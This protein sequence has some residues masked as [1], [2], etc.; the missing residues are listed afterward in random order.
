VIGVS[1]Q[2]LLDIGQDGDFDDNGLCPTSIVPLSDGRLRMYYFGFQLLHKVPYTMF[3]GIAESYDGGESFVRIQRTPTLDRTPAEPVMRSGPFVLQDG[4]RFKVWYPCGSRWIEVNGKKVHE[5]HLRYAESDDG[6]R[7]PD[8]GKVAVNIRL[9][10]EYGLGRPYVLR[11]QDDYLLFYSMRTHSLGYRLGYATS[12]NGILWTRRDALG[13]DVSHSGWDSEI[14]CYSS[15]MEAEGRVYLFYNG[16]DLGKSGFGYAEGDPE[17][18]AA[19][20]KA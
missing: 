15:V 12:P 13:I 2:P 4:Q 5:Y 1:Q 20:G 10:D 6:I 3:S 16:N 18:F 7:W 19:L 9:P 14:Q 11:R 8:E 17:S